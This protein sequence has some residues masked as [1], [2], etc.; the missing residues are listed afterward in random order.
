MK[1]KERIDTEKFMCSKHKIDY[2]LLCEECR[3]KHAR[4]DKVLIDIRLSK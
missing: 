4:F 3:E 1:K 2:R